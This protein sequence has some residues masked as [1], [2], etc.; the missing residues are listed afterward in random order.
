MLTEQLIRQNQVRH[1]ELLW[2][3]EQARKKSGE[4]RDSALDRILAGTGDLLVVA[5]E[6]LRRRYRRMEEGV[7]LAEYG[8]S[9]R[10]ERAI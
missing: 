10:M 3:A 8:P 6:G 5:G 2:E 4:T 7:A 9:Q 1:Q